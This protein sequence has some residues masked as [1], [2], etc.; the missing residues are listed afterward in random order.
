VSELIKFKDNSTGKVIAEV[1][2]INVPRAGETVFI[3]NKK[4]SV[5][6][7][8]WVYT[9]PRDTYPEDPLT[10]EDVF[11]YLNFIVGYPKK[12]KHVF[13]ELEEE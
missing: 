7:V 1:H 10:Y 4:Y 13:S 11:V 5:E 6:K 12:A 2:Q 3:D 8:V 9:D